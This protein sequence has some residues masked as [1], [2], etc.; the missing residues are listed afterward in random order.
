MFPPMVRMMQRPRQ[1]A[2]TTVCHSS[3]GG[4]TGDIAV[5]P[6][7]VSL[8]HG[9]EPLMPNVGKLEFSTVDEDSASYSGPQL[10]SLTQV[11]LQAELYHPF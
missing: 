7:P 8:A 4:R 10:L 2:M 5:E 1:M 11:Y 9:Q 3:N 6:S